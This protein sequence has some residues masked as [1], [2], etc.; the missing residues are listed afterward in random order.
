MQERV[1]ANS[2]CM[3]C[4]G[5]LGLCNHAPPHMGEGFHCVSCVCIHDYRCRISTA[6]GRSSDATT[7][8]TASISPVVVSMAS[9]TAPKVPLPS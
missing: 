6:L 4:R 2:P 1:A 9:Y 7:C 3:P 8:F 5:G